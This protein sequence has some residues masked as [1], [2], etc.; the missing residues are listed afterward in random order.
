MALA[1][2]DVPGLVLYGGS[3]AP[4]RCADDDLTIQDVFEAVG[5]HGAGRCSASELKA[6]EDG[7]C[8]GAGACGG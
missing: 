7:A 4:G 6:V 3:T 1:R 8:P 2:L 5:A